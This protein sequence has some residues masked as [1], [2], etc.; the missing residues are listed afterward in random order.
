VLRIEMQSRNMPILFP[1]DTTESAVDYDFVRLAIPEPFL[2]PVDAEVL[3]CV[4][5]SSNCSRNK[6]EF[7]N[8]R[9]FGSE[10]SITFDNKVPQ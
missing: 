5:G 9:K 4:R 3:S 7:R 10:S 2:L 1:F 8:Y 6:I